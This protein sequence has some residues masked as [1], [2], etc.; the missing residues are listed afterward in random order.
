MKIRLKA[1]EG[2][3]STGIY[4]AEGKEYEVGTILDVK[5]SPAG[6]KGRYDE[7]GGDTAGKE[8]VTNPKGGDKAFTVSEKSPGWYVITNKDGAETKSLRKSDIESFE[9]WAEG[10][11][12][13][14]FEANKAD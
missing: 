2:L 5:E 1:P 10:D 6:W 11:Q 8:P 13:Q 3:S 12:A 4:G 9:T 14:Y 7:I